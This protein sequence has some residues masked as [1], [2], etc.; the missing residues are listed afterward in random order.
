MLPKYIEKKIDRMERLIGEA[1]TLK[2][3]IEKWAVKKGID[4]YSTDNHERVFF[5]GFGVCCIDKLGLLEM[6]EELEE[7]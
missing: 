7:N 3:E 1:I 4:I 2:G 5:D 6:L